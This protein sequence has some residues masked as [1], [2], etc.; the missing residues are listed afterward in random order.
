MSGGRLAR[1][2][3]R[4]RGNEKEIC[5][6]GRTRAG[7]GAPLLRR[8]ERPDVRQGPVQEYRLRGRGGA[9]RSASRTARR[10]GDG[11]RLHATE[12]GGAVEAPRMPR[13]LV[14]RVG[15][16]VTLDSGP[17]GIVDADL[18]DT[19]EGPG[20]AGFRNGPARA[21]GGGLVTSAA[22]VDNDVFENTSS[23]AAPGG[24]PGDP[25]RTGFMY[26]AKEAS[27][28]ASSLFADL[29]MAL[30]GFRSRSDSGRALTRR[31][32]ECACGC[33]FLEFDAEPHIMRIHRLSK[34]RQADFE[35]CR[36]RTG[37][38]LELRTLNVATSREHV[39][40]I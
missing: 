37:P 8:A 12:R 1:D 14:G 17:Q 26:R 4:R 15:T 3:A 10:R 40:R 5:G 30:A 6:R 2:D 27:A 33:A 19:S 22:F 31:V 7:V 13:L 16:H 11:G 25:K 28:I 38:G 35:G 34:E 32:C 29:P 20:S 21:S 18:R 39:D 9:D 23:P 24:D 36:H